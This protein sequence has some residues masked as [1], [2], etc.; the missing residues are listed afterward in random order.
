MI[1]WG[2][3]VGSIAV[4][5]IVA[6]LG[7][8]PSMTYEGFRLIGF[9]VLFIGMAIR[10]HAI[11]TLGR[12]FS[13]HVEMHADHKL[14]QSGLYQYVRHP[15]YTGLLVSFIGLG[16]ALGN[17]L[18]LALLVIPIAVAL[19]YRIEVEEKALTEEFGDAYTAYCVQAKRLIP[20]IY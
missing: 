13:V 17:W 1:L 10:G 14:I 18:S 20:W 5:I 19:A 16:I 6:L 9:A 7:V 15:S 8:H 12:F 2:V 11:Y 3:G 4:S